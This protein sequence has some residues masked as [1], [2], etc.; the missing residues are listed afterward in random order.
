MSP[1]RIEDTSSSADLATALSDSDSDT[2]VEVEQ[3]PDDDIIRFTTLNVERMQIGSAGTIGIGNAAISTIGISIN[4][5]S[6]IVTGIG[7]GNSR[8]GIDNDT[9]IDLASNTGG[10]VK[11][12]N[13]FMKISSST[14]K[15]LGTGI[16]I[17]PLLEWN[18]NGTLT[19]GYGIKSDIVTDLGTITT[20]YGLASTL[21]VGTGTT[22]TN[23]AG[24]YLKTPT[25]AGTLTNR[26][27]IYQEDT[28]AINLFNGFVDLESA[29]PT[30][31]GMR[32][33]GTSSGGALNFI[34][35]RDGNS[36][37]GSIIEIFGLFAFAG[38]NSFLFGLSSATD[39]ILGVSGNISYV[40]SGS[41]DFT[42]PLTTNTTL[43]INGGGTGHAN[44]RLASVAAPTSPVSGDV[45]NDST[46]KSISVYTDDIKEILSTTI[47]TQTADKVVSNTTSETSIIGTGV[48]SLTLPANFF[49]AGKTIRIRIGGIYS[50]PAIATPSLLI[51][52][53]YG[54]TV[55]ASVT[56]TGLL[57]GASKLEFDGEVAI[58]CRSTGSSGTVSIHG[59][60]EYATG[61][62]GTISVDPLNNAGGSATINT[63]TSNLLDIT[64]TWDT[65]TNTR[66]VTSTVSIVERL[67]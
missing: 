39:Y 65:A 52:V 58:T 38:V 8:T 2:K 61:V 21:T 56:T 34:D 64:V 3:T 45:W 59:D 60:V 11:G 7:A 36:S 63:T 10:T 9:L 5:A 49:V 26:Y 41:H 51:K 29:T 24:L 44:L 18:S 20:A 4:Y 48:G 30:T 47:F 66:N 1:I 22:V 46:Q 13:G 37:I 6:S 14:S 62:G 40:S 55:L 54:S 25:V 33:N 35:F 17:N 15:N 16:S 23:F 27:G 50:T 28:S 57:S 67:N 43:E 42:G 19:T 31:Y 53:K 32:I 12:L